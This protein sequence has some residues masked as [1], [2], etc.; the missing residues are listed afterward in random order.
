MSMKTISENA[1]K[2]LKA[3]AVAGA[4]HEDAMRQVLFP[5]PKYVSAKTDPEAN[6]LY[7]EYEALCFGIDRQDMVEHRTIKRALTYQDSYESIA[8]RA[9]IELGKAGLARERNNGFN[10]Y[11]YFITNKGRAAAASLR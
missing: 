9:R 10:C 5:A 4:M 8:S 2:M 7:Y 6:A 3:L 11:T 1:A